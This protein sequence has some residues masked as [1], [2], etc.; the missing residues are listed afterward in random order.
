MFNTYEWGDY[1]LWKGPQRAKVFV[2]THAHVLP[3]KVWRHY[4]GVVRMRPGWE[5]VLEHYDVRT[6]VLD[7]R[8]RGALIRALKRMPGWTLRYEDGLGAAFV[9]SEVG[10]R[11]SERR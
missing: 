9:K 8:Y 6:V 3:P 4:M 1:L 7:R 11:K 5:R 2:A 10:S